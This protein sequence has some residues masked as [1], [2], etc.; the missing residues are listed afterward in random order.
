MYNIELK[1]ALIIE[2]SGGGSGRHV[3]DLAKGLSDAGHSITIFWSPVRAESE[4]VTK[5]KEL[6]NVHNHN[7]DLY[8]SVGFHDFVSLKSLR[9]EL[10]RLG[11]FDV[12]HAHSSKAGALVRLLPGSIPGKR[13]YTPHA[14]R[15]MD[16]QIKPLAR[17]FVKTVE[18]LLSHLDGTIIAVSEFEYQHARGI[19][20]S[21]QKLKK[22]VNA[23]PSI[24]TS[25]RGKARV[26]LGVG[27]TDFSVGFV[28]RLV[29]QKNPQLFVEALQIASKDSP[30]IK[31]IVIGD[32]VLRDEAESSNIE[33][34]CVFL[35][36]QNAQA[37]MQG[38]D[39]FVM[40]SLYEAMPYTMLEALGCNLP[41]LST[42]VGGVEEAVLD[43]VNGIILEQSVSPSLLAERIIEIYKDTDRRQK[44]A[45]ASGKLYRQYTIE[46]M[47]IKT[48]EAY[49]E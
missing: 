29:H 28:G 21:T 4:W 18:R 20:I 45:D 24:D 17:F 39:L 37:L 11:P 10:K 38:F 14:F 1:I 26:N 16:P 12:L 47:V 22:I 6:R 44:W 31:G 36:Q 5:V 23:I 40:T 19:G 33:S 46:K 30:N 15:T 43:G 34:A 7:V 25:Q 49:I 2:P 42:R 27:V 13:V 35:G 8:R 3:L 9:R 48:I 32:G 41:I